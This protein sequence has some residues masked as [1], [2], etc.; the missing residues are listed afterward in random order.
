MARSYGFVCLLCVFI[1]YQ[2][3]ALKLGWP[4]MQVYHTASFQT[5]IARTT[6]SQ[7][8]ATSYSECLN[9]VSYCLCYLGP[10]MFAP[11]IVAD[12]I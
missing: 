3:T 2:P 12:L 6:H 8:V 4:C 5:G 1:R 10:F 7:T 11:V 9:L